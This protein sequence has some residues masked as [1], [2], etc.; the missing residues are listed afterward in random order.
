MLTGIGSIL[1]IFSDLF[2]DSEHVYLPADT[3]T[4]LFEGS[5]LHGYYGVF[6]V[7]NQNG[8]NHVRGQ[9]AKI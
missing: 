3:D 6:S 8:K 2:V 5:Y 1:Q 7:L 9:R 4:V